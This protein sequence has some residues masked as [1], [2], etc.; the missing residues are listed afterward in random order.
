MIES[1][2]AFASTRARYLEAPLLK[3]RVDYLWHLHHQ[4]RNRKHLRLTAARLLNSIEF[5]NL[6]NARPVDRL[7]ILNAGARWAADPAV[8]RRGKGTKNSAY[9]FSRTTIQWLRFNGLFVEVRKPELPFDA[10]VNSHL[11]NLQVIKGLSPVTVSNLRG[12]LSKFQKWVAGREI[13]I[14]N[15]TLNDLDA[16]LDLLQGKGW[17]PRSIASTSEALRGFFR[18]CEAKEYCAPGIARGILSPRFSQRQPEPRGPAWRDVRR[19]LRSLTG[20]SPA[21][22]RAKAIISL[23]SIYALRRGEVVRLRLRDFDWVNETLTIQ[24]S[25]R[26]RVQHFP[27]QYEVGEAILKYLQLGRP[28]CHCPYLFTTLVTP[29]R[30]MGPACLWKIVAK[31]L[32]GLG[33]Q[34]QNYG[35]HSLRH[36]SA[37]KLLR[38]GSSLRDIADFL[39]HRG[40]SAVTVYAKYDPRLLRRVGSFSL[41]GVQ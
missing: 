15:I 2:F 16:F 9:N 18:Y 31:R 32:K 4:G 35:P 29:Y 8:G 6:T 34:S 3:E 33:I 13:S 11:E 41:A 36:A 40:L 23:C 1:L 30:P 17:R 39:G 38:A 7:E 26:G 12:R 25:K 37:T 20:T 10:L 28:K 19:L 5:L 14:E 21:E 27:I 24:R 22:L